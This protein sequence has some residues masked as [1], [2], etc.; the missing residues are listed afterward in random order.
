MRNLV[1]RRV[2]VGLSDSSSWRASL[3]SASLST[4]GVLEITGF[5]SSSLVLIV[6][7]AFFRAVSISFLVSSREVCHES[8]FCAELAEGIARES[9][10]N[11]GV[12]GEGKPCQRIGVR[13]FLGVCGSLGCE[14]P[15]T[16]SLLIE[17]VLLNGFGLLESV[18]TSRSLRRRAKT[19]SYR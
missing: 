4:S 18:L 1:L 19:A 16:S 8:S 7:F 6:F 12:S 5:I 2:A 14:V 11:V 10:R 15:S 9:L 13:F 3:A 17:M